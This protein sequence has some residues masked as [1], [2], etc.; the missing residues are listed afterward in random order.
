MNRKLSLS[1]LMSISMAAPQLLAKEG[2]H[3]ARPGENHGSA[4]PAFN[5]G[6]NTS[7]SAEVGGS[8]HGASL[9]FNGEIRGHGRGDDNS[10][11]GNAAVDAAVQKVKADAQ[12]VKADKNSN[13]S[14]LSADLATLKSDVAALRALK[15]EHQASGN[16][17][18]DDHHFDHGKD[19]E[20]HKD[21]DDAVMSDPTVAAAAA[22]VKADFDAIKAD[23]ASGSANLQADM[24]TL[25]S[26][27]ATLK[28][29]IATAK[30]NLKGKTDDDTSTP[31]SNSSSS[32]TTAGSS[33]S[34]AS[35]GSTGASADSSASGSTSTV[36]ST[37]S[38]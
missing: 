26:D 36:A 14:N 28:S 7:G 33:G 29:D 12:Q 6:L 38:N 11:T 13:S 18:D 27:M 20:K 3:S 2:G 32:S 9:G 37:N 16:K 4:A 31:S 10:G 8:S 23:K 34:T 19:R 30:A 22:K 1:I 17:A 35:S 21:H 24:A 5:A 15:P 25:K